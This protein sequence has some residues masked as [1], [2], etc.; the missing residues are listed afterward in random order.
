MKT[1]LTIMGPTASGKTDCALQLAKRF[2]IE[3]VSVDS[4]L[5]YRGMDIGTAKPDSEMLAQVPHHLID[6][7]DPAEAYSAADFVADALEAI[8]GIHSRKKLPVLVGGTMLYFKALIEGIA[9][10]PDADEAIRKNIQ[11]AAEDK[12]WAWCHEKLKQ[13]DPLA[14]ERI[15]PNDAQRI[16]RALEVFEA[17][18]QSMTELQQSSSQSSDFQWTQT[19][20]FPTDRAELHQRIAKRFEVMLSQGFVDE[21]RALYNRDDLNETLPS[22]RAV[23]YRQAWQYLEGVCEYGDMIDKGIAATRQ[24]AKR[25]LTW[26]RGWPELQLFD[27]P[28]QLIDAISP[29]LDTS[30]SSARTSE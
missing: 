10:L 17:S 1:V 24:L 29:E 27:T 18:G 12:G 8:R 7:R 19:A 13:V 30:L 20:I 5:V 14:A 16:Q 15:H 25:Q 28:T 4:A 23:G 9:D 3:I 22:M 6:I 26:L 11:K 2:P 21:V